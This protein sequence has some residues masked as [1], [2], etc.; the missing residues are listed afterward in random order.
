[1]ETCK[2]LYTR[3]NYLKN[4][5]SESAG[6][7]SILLFTGITGKVKDTNRHLLEGKPKGHSLKCISY[8]YIEQHGEGNLETF[9]TGEGDRTVK[10]QRRV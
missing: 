10:I 4:T 7:Y 3:L 5:T 6:Y 9:P 2:E 8:M 1:M